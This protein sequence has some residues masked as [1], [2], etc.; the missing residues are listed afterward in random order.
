MSSVQTLVQILLELALISTVHVKGFNPTIHTQATIKLICEY[1]PF[2][3]NGCP[4]HLILRYFL[5]SQEPLL[6]SFISSTL[7]RNLPLV[8]ILEQ[9]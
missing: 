2:L 6:G 1:D 4:L 9:N 8:W 5:V 3:I 7:L